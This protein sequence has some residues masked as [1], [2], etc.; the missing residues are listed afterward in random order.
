MELECPQP[1]I[2]L[3][4][5]TFLMHLKEVH[6]PHMLLVSLKS[7]LIYLHLMSVPHMQY[8]NCTGVKWLLL[9]LLFEYCLK[10]RHK[11]PHLML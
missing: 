5:C 2:K 6:C 11:L 1:R 10:F 9:I 7:S 4:C 8:L 3:V